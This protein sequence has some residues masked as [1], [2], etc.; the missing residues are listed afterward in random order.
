MAQ[1]TVEGTITDVYEDPI[2]GLNVMIKNSVVGTVTD[3]NGNYSLANVPTD[4]ILV[5]SSIGIET[6][7]IPVNGQ[8]RIDLIMLED[9]SKLDEV[10]VIGYG[11]VKKRDLTG[12]VSSVKSEDITISPVNNVME[13]L[14]GRVSGLDITRSSGRSGSDPE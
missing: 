3:I 7:E 6:Q 5:F 2:P 1:I 10:I 4:G 11:T 12:A 8:K 9:I 14:Q 13:A